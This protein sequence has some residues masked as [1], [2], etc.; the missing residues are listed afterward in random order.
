[1]LFIMHVLSSLLRHNHDNCMHICWLHGVHMRMHSAVIN[2]YA[3]ENEKKSAEALKNRYF[4]LFK[5]LI[6]SSG[7]P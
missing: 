6:H 4:D 3:E 1:M 5:G 2:M 7:S